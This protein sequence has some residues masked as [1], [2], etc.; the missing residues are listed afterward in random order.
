MG[1]RMVVMGG[2]GGLGFMSL[3]LGLLVPWWDWGRGGAFSVPCYFYVYWILV[4]EQLGVG[5]RS[6]GI[7][8]DV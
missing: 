7:R 5:L 1:L 4:M 3:A 8:D 6:T 2:W